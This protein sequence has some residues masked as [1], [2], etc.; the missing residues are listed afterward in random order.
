M[1]G[2]KP[3]DYL[4]RLQSLGVTAVE[5]QLPPDLSAPEIERWA[6]LVDLARERRLK[7]AIHAPI[8]L[9]TPI[10]QELYAWFGQMAVA[11][12]TLVVHSATAGRPD[13][14]LVAQT[15]SRVHAL[16]AALPPTMTVAVEQGWSWGRMIGL[17]AMVR[18]LRDSRLSQGME[19]QRLTGVGSAMG[20]ELPPAI[21][22]VASSAANFDPSFQS[23]W[24][25]TLRRTDGFSGT[26]TREE[27][28]QVV[29]EVNRPNCVIAWDLAHDWLGG[30]KGRVA[31][32]RS[33]PTS[34]FLDRVGYV[35]LHDVNA[36][37]C[38]HWPLVVGNVPY[39]SQLRAL[40]RHGFAGTV[41]LAIRY[42]QE[43]I[44]F[45]D[46]WQVLERSLAVTRQV[47]RLN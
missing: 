44:V 9:G 34:D 35:R 6:A 18:S 11:P 20:A 40:L 23:G 29:M 14:G 42:T 3:A 36:K 41:C 8:A 33:T 47:L 28:L 30:A 22:P 2:L 16:L 19:R 43:M 12:L 24:W 5:A 25:R 37:G 39:T 17:G 26:A 7:L 46:R 15:V 13:A 27:A 10:W 31:D 45:G 4:D 38:D 32:W 21:Q 1:G